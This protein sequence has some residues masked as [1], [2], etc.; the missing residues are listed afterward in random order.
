MATFLTAVFGFEEA[1]YGELDEHFLDAFVALRKSLS[2]AAGGLFLALKTIVRVCVGDAGELGDG[3]LARLFP[4]T[5]GILL[6]R[7]PQQKQLALSELAFVR[8]LQHWRMRM[9]SLRQAGVRGGPGTW[10]VF[11]RGL[12]AYVAQ[13]G[14]ESLV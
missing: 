6:A 13:R 3:L 2:E 5:T 1:S 14:E 12:S 11:L 9:N 4:S 7:H 10:R 8:L